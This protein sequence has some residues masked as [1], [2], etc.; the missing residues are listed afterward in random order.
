[1][2]CADNGYARN[3]Q[4][5]KSNI[6][7]VVGTDTTFSL[8]EEE[9]RCTFSTYDSITGNQYNG[10]SS[11]GGN[12]VSE[13]VIEDAVGGA[14]EVGIRGVLSTGWNYSFSSKNKASM[15]GCRVSS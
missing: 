12:T 14:S 8:K 15:V 3:V 7:R 11:R 2:L 13:V 5:S 1:V 6:N 10:T 4:Y 9:E